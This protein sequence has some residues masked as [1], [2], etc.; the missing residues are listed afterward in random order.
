MTSVE[1]PAAPR[2]L[3]HGTNTTLARIGQVLCLVVPIILW[4]VPLNLEPQTQHGFAIVAFMVIAWI[5]QATEF[6]LAGFIGCFLFWALGIVVARRPD[7]W[8]SSRSGGCST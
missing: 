2:E 5:T 1:A 4:F 8:S 6:A 3:E 7:R